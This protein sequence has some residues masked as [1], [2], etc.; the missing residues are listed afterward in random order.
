MKHNSVHHTY[1]G[2]SAKNSDLEPE[3]GLKRHL[4]NTLSL[5][6]CKET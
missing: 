3:K 6:L 4:P 5:V 2:Q 1:S